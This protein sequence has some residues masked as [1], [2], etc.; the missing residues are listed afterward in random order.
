MSYESNLNQT[1]IIE[2]LLL[3]IYIVFT[4]NY[5]FN[6]LMMYP[7]PIF[8]FNAFLRASFTFADVSLSEA[9]GEVCDLFLI[10]NLF[11]SS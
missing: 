11:F 4:N 3:N 6:I 1:I 8:N 7:P 2:T 9:K 10:K 5:F